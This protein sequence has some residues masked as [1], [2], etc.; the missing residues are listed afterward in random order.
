MKIFINMLFFMFCF[1]HLFLFMKLSYLFI[2]VLSFVFFNIKDIH[3]LN[4]II[5]VLI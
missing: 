5:Y 1:L 4:L 2:F 3:F